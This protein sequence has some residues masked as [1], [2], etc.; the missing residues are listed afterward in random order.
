[1]ASSTATRLAGAVTASSSFVV[2]EHIFASAKL[3]DKFLGKNG[4][5]AKYLQA[6]VSGLRIGSFGYISYSLDARLS[7]D[8]DELNEVQFVLRRA[9]PSISLVGQISLPKNDAIW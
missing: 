4:I 7:S 1:M 3:L 6:M 5:L 9:G 2:H 8:N